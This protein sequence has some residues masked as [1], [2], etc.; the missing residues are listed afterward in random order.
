[1]GT[2][3]TTIRAGFALALALAGTLHAADMPALD[4]ND[5]RVGDRKALREMLIATEQAFNKVDLDAVLR[6]LE[7][8]AVVVWQDGVR[9]TGHD[10]VRE[11]YKRTF[12][13]A[14]G[15]ILKSMSIKAALSAPAHFYGEQYAVAYG[16]TK[17]NY[18]L[19]GGSTVSLDGLW[20]SHVAK[21]DGAWKITALHFSTNPFDND[22]LRKAGHAAWI[23]GIVG[24]AAGLIVGWLLGRRRK[25]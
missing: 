21:R 9:T 1:M 5:P 17:E 20:T 10:Q 6:V 19:V 3:Q 18:D 24:A 23:F 16:T 4:P 14:G 25:T 8:D 15:A 22:V 2:K 11:H 7:K 13:G 12:Q